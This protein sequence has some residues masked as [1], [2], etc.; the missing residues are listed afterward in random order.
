VLTTDTPAAVASPPAGTSAGRLGRLV[1]RVA[2]AAVVLF[3]VLGIG[4][5]LLGLATFANTD[6]LVSNSPYVS[7]GY[8]V[9]HVQNRI[10]NDIVASVLPSTSLFAEELKRGNLAAWNPYV[11]GGNP[12]GAV[13]NFAVLSPLTLPYYILPSD[14]APAFVKVLEIVV[15]AGGAYLFLRRLQLGA[16]AA[17][18]GGLAFASSGFMIAWTNWPQTRVA[19]FIPAV[20]WAAERL[21][22]ERRVRDGAL[23]AAALAAMLAGG[24]PAV[25]GYTVLTAGAY[26]IVRAAAQGRAVGPVLAGAGAVVGAVMLTAIQLLPFVA[27]MRHARLSN[28]A[29]TGADHLDPAALL[30]SWAPWSLGGVNDFLLGDNAV[31]ALSYVGAAS[32]VLFFLAVA[33][34]TAARA[35]LPR[36]V[37][38]FTVVAT[39][40]WA[41]LI[42]VGGFPLALLQKLPVLFSDNFVGRARSVLGFLVAVLVATGFEIALRRARAAAAAE[43]PRPWRRAERV[44]AAGVAVFAVLAIAGTLWG[45]WSVVSAE[46]SAR[47]FATRA[48][49]GLVFMGV[50]ALAVW[51][52]GRGRRAVVV[53]AALVLPVL[54]MAQAVATVRP[55]WPRVDRDTWYPQTEV[56]RYL[57]GNLGHDRFAEAD[58]GMYSGADSPAKLRSL[59]GEA[60]FDR[61]FAE[62]VEGLPGELFGSTL[63]RL[64]ATE[65][66]ARSPILDRL[67]VRYLVTTPWA[68]VFGEQAVDPG[69]GSTVTITP[70]EP[71]SVPLAVRGPIRGV[72]LT[73]QAAVPRSTRVEVSI[74]DAGGRELARGG[75]TGSRTKPGQ[76]V[77]VAVPGDGIPAGTPLTAVFTVTGSRPVAVAADGGRPAVSTVAAREDDGL[78]VAYAGSSTVWER[79]TA[80][81]RIRWASAVHVGADTAARVDALAGTALKP[82]QVVLDSAP[83]SP[84]AGR[85]ATVT[86]TEDGTDDIEA[87]VDAEGDGYL[88]VADALQ[89]GWAATVDGRPAALVPADN[90]LVAVAV[91]AGSHTVRLE[92]RMPL[93]NAGAWISGAALAALLG[94]GLGVL[95][96][97]RRTSG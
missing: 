91:P 36:G 72:A 15:A 54:V 8:A 43:R 26:L 31:E 65:E 88:V 61:R 86:V 97:R 7:E 57:A 67:A 95:V 21:A 52:M 82:D 45:G 17:W 11:A 92:Y 10:A 69:D 78:R 42:Y 64:P 89:H 68:P 6:L 87:R 49:A 83:A 16:A 75:R 81:P 79:T 76:P 19:A 32:L 12:L 34:P 85:P 25:T 35:V 66:M 59:T 58:G 38:T 29:Q 18:L 55:Y 13:P 50:A 4:A 1:D 28:R 56:H 53:A 30:T 40:V 33:L 47:T 22:T 3:A 62:T 94:I 73:W 2:F 9:P 14:L 41:L 44:W 90:G 96:R 37:W 60:F 46:G 93:G 23:L 71:A 39:A 20:F 27:G 74:R 80:L 77:W 70:G 5:P 48:G 51:A 63:L 24:F 84:P